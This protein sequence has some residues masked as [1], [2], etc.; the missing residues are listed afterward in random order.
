MMIAEQGEQGGKCASNK[1]PGSPSS[2]MLNRVLC[3]RREASECPVTQCITI[4]AENLL[5]LS[6]LK[7]V[8]VAETAESIPWWLSRTEIQRGSSRGR[9]SPCEVS[10][11][12]ENQVL[13]RGEWG[14]ML[15]LGYTLNYISDSLD[16]QEFTMNLYDKWMLTSETNSCNF[17]CSRT[18]GGPEV[19]KYWYSF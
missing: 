7:W 10:P 11:G 9:K 16:Q 19:Q 1:T 18:Q 15:L 12:Q 4:W 13:S 5:K 6:E 2:S 8:E 14:Y 3:F 17:I